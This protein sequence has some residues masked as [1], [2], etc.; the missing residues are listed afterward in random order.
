MQIENININIYRKKKKKTAFAKVPKN[1]DTDLKILL[2][3]QLK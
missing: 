3:G 2:F 1:L